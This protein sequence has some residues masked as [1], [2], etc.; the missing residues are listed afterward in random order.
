MPTPGAFVEPGGMSPEDFSRTA[1]Q[2]TEEFYN[3]YDV[4]DQ[5]QTNTGPISFSYGEHVKS[6]SDIDYVPFVER[7]ENRA[8]FHYSVLAGLSGTAKLPFAILRRDWWAV[9]DTL[10]VVVIYFRA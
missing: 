7:A 1:S 5:S 2:P 10:V 4:S 6:C 3:E 9:P 8:R